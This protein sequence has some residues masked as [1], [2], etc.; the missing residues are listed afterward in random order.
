MARPE[1]G[2]DPEM[3][4]RTQKLNLTFALTSL[5]LLAALSW[6]IWADYSREWKKYQLEFNRMEVQRTEEQIQQAR[7]KEDAKKLQEI[8][9]RHAQGEQE[10]ATRA[11]EIARVREELATLQAEWYRTDQ[12]YRFTKAN[13]DVYKYRYEEAAHTSSSHAAAEQKKLREL[14]ARWAEER[15]KLES[16]KAD[17]AAAQAKK[18]DLEK[19][20][21]AAEVL[22]KE[23]YTVKDRLD[24]KL[25]SLQPG[26][27]SFVRNMPVLDM[28][29]PSL[30]VQQILP[31]NLSDDVIFTGTPKVDRC[32]TCHLGID[33][34]GF[35]DAPQP[36][37][38][39]PNVELYVQG[40][41]AM[42]RIGCTVCH[43]GRGRATGF[44]NA[45]HTPHDKEQETAWGK[46]SKT[47]EYER[48]HH[49]DLPM[50]AKGHTE[51]QCVKCHQGVVEVPKATRLNMG[52]QLVEKFGCYGCHKIKGWENL[53]KAGPDLTKVTSKTTEDWI[54]RWIKEPK[55]FRPTRMPQ[56]WGV[57]SLEHE[58]EE[59][60]QRS[61]ARDDAE[62]NAVAAFLV[63]SAETI[64]Y[65]APPA[66][67][68]TAGRKA[69]ET[70]GCLGCHRIG[71]DNRGMEIVKTGD[72]SVPIPAASFR[73]HGPNLDGTGTKLNAGWVYA[74]I[75]NPKGYWHETRMPNLR[76]SDKE[77][78]D[79]T[80]YLM[81]LKNDEFMA[82]PR[83]AMNAQVRDEI[84]LEYLT[85]TLPVAPAQAK[86]K[87]MDDAQKTMF[88]GEKTI[89]RQGCFGCHNIKGFEKT[90]PIGVELTEE[91]SKLV[92]RLDFGFQHGK[93][94]H[95]LPAWVHLKLMDPRI[96]DEGK[97]QTKRPEE[98]LR[99][100][101]FHMSDEEADAVVTAV[102]SF[103]K[104]Q[105]PAAAQ[106]QVSADERYV[107]D[108]R[109]L[110]REFNCQGC[111]QIG[112][113]GGAIKAV[114]TDN[115]V[116]AGGDDM[117]AGALSPPMLYNDKSKIGEGARVHTDWLHGFLGDPSKKIRP[118]LDIRMP[119][120][121]FTEEQ[122][123]AITRYFAA[124]DKVAYPYEPAPAHDPAL[125]AAGQQL[126]TKWQCVK[127]HVVAGKL[128]EGQEPANM[129]PDLANVPNRLRADWLA[130]W[131]AKP[132]AIIPGTRM[133]SNFPADPKQNAFPEFFGGDQKKQIEAVRAYL[134]TLGGGKSRAGSGPIASR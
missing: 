81:S 98:W 103:T 134:L 90:S 101:K 54:Y 114:I 59:L 39:H 9:A 55:G 111:H 89:A 84:I 20:K 41:H 37:T 102:L 73:T 77:A 27:V 61:Q 33:R 82:R 34:K 31:A 13:I 113:R 65:P 48:I 50:L 14:E 70:V 91:G 130:Q 80:S 6:M 76:L 99:M 123:N 67:D 121:E 60:K 71:N 68:L 118:W 56:V 112:E 86:L 66:G 83:P 57:R 100:P 46:Y 97:H 23:L 5:G 2:R 133:P 120:F 19:S 122:L 128:P 51:S 44:V 4:E 22:H 49:W 18:A 24:K 127:C 124:Q 40:S 126:F 58:P 105:V 75:K 64:Q 129:A 95:T 109:R 11:G 132:S 17:L 7:G 115:L 29:N 25:V 87:E 110:V 21:L 119:T 79:V 28:A 35:E 52:K 107:E 88:L 92:E 38:T 47:K 15:L 32:I 125:V 63:K 106:K 26:F 30:K 10:A 93:I 3:V 8:Q 108:G 94:P 45:V 16:V 12:D 96:Y 69:F 104:E 53:R 62:A 85:N 78:A 42:D 74:W 43:Q 117:Q 1:P 116:R 72:R 36:F 131:L